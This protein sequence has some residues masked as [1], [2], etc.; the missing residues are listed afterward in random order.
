MVSRRNSYLSADSVLTRIEKNPHKFNSFQTLATCEGFRIRS[1]LTID[2]FFPM[3]E[4]I[5]QNV[6]AV[7]HELGLKQKVGQLVKFYFYLGIIQEKSL[8]QEHECHPCEVILEHLMGYLTIDTELRVIS[9]MNV[10][11]TYKSPILLELV[12]LT[13]EKTLL[14]HPPN[15]LPSISTLVRRLTTQL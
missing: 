15:T 5:I 6:C 1:S 14:K 7:W 8:Q 11:L 3:L 2:D 13:K 12:R 9:S 4:K 10:D